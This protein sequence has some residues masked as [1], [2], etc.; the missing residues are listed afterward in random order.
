MSESPQS[1]G[2]LR[3]LAATAAF[4]VVH[5]VLASRAAKRAASRLAGERTRGGWYRVAF[6]AQAVATF[7][8]LAAYGRGL[9]DRTLYEVRGPLALLMR[10]GQLAG[11]AWAAW[12]V[13]EIGLARI[14]GASSARA[15]V[16]GEGD[17]PAEP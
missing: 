14:S 3:I 9:P 17:V 8:A 12:T 4:A 6:N 10:A 15:W 1:S 11:L 2:V 16:A 13:R 7:G 5:S